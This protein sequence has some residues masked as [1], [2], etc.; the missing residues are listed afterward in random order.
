MAVS[1]LSQPHEAALE[2]FPSKVC[3]A[4]T[5]RSDGRTRYMPFIAAFSKIMIISAPEFPNY[6]PLT[7]VLPPSTFPLGQYMARL[8]ALGWATVLYPQ[9]YEPPNKLEKYASSGVLI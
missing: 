9:S 2:S 7:A 3:Q 8:P 5:S 6:S 1:K 4:L